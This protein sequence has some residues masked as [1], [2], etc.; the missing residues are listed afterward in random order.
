MADVYDNISFIRTA[1]YGRE[2]RTAIADSIEQCYAHATGDPNSL[3]SIIKA[4]A[5]GATTGDVAD[6]SVSESVFVDANRYE[7][8]QI[9][10]IDLTPGVWLICMNVYSRH[11]VSLNDDTIYTTV[12]SFLDSDSIEGT[13]SYL[14]TESMYSPNVIA[15]HPKKRQQYSTD[16]NAFVVT[17]AD[18]DSRLVDGVIPFWLFAWTNCD[19]GGYFKSTLAAI[20]IGND[21]SDDETSVV[22]QVAEN[23]AAIAN[24]GTLSTDISSIR[25]QHENDIDELTDLIEDSVVSLRASLDEKTFS[26]DENDYLTLD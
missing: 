23:T 15:W 13:L 18:D 1:H 21:G 20:K 9:N 10:S 22:E 11:V 26:L 7:H 25:S 19:L 4:L 14:E 24:L 8:T 12:I 5:R 3:S 6:G 2:V 16:G 17:I